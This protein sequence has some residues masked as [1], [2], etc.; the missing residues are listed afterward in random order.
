VDTSDP[1]E[2]KVSVVLKY[3]DDDTLPPV[4]YSV[5]RVKNTYQ[6]QKQVCVFDSIPNSPTKGTAQCSKSYTPHYDGTLSVSF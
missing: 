4:D 2:I 3:K 5:V 1:T 6:V